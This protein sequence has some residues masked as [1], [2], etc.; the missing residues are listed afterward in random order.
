VK[1]NKKEEEYSSGQGGRGGNGAGRGRGFERGKG[2][3]VINFYHCGVEG[4]K[5][6]ECP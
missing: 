1:G 2:I 6:P 5:K 4:H 3:Y